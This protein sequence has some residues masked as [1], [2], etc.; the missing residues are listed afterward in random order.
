MDGQFLP[1]QVIHIGK[2]TKSIPRVSFPDGFLV[3]A[4]LKNYSNEEES[5]KMMEHIIIPYVENQRKI[6]KL[7]AQYPPMLMMDVFKGQMID[8]MKEI[9]EEKQHRT[10]ES[11]SQ[12]NVSLPATR[13]TRWS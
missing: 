11:S 4:N 8:P 3:S 10:P 6:L 9:F 12:S 7:D 2:T 13:C 1:M 5:L